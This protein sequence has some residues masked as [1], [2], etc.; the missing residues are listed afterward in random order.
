MV[1]KRRKRPHWGSG[2][3]GYENM[4]LMDKVEVNKK[5]LLFHIFTLCFRRI[6]LMCL[7]IVSVVFSTCFIF[8]YPFLQWLFIEI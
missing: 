4:T 3:F 8:F 1:K 6:A 2:Y 7:V 5:N